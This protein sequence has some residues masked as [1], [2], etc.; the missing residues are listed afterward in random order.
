MTLAGD[1]HSGRLREV[2]VFQREGEACRRWFTCHGADL[3]LWQAA[4]GI[5]AFEFCH[6]RPHDE[7][8][9]RWREGEGF[10]HARVDDGE[11]NPVRRA[12]SRL[13]S[14]IDREVYRFVLVRLVAGG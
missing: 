9:L 14:G 12:V 7:H 1:G 2:R 11:D 4:A 10:R 8:A 3:V 6:D 5:R 13:G